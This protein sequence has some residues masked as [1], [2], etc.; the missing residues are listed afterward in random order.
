[1]VLFG[2]A[3]GREKDR[4]VLADDFVR[5]IAEEPFRSWVPAADL[6]LTQLG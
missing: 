2:E 5:A 1:V 6:L 3:I 4:D